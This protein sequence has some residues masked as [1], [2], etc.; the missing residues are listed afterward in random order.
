[1]LVLAAASCLPAATFAAAPSPDARF[2]TYKNQFLLTL[3]R[4]EPGLAT[5]KGYHKYDSLLVIPDAAQRLRNAKFV[6]ANLATLG[7]FRLASLSPANQL[8]LRTTPRPA[9]TSARPP[10]NTPS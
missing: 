4:L 2:D 8:D 10:R 5:T 1:M 3:W 9:P 6:Q 7:S